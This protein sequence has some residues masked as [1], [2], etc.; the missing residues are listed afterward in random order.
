MKEY[1]SNGQIKY[2]AKGPKLYKYKV[3]CAGGK[4]TIIWATNPNAAEKQ[5]KNRNLTPLSIKMG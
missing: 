2:L 5:A 3:L 4:T 1:F